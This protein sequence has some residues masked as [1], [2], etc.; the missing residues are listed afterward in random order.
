[1]KTPEL[2]NLESLQ[3]MCLRSRGCRS[4]PNVCVCV[5]I[6]RAEEGELAP[7]AETSPG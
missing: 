4:L 7:N 1:M 2:P 5:S 3:G 6:L